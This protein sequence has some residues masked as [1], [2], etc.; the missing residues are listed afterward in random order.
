M[1]EE[2]AVRT[3]MVIFAETNETE[4]YREHAGM[5]KDRDGIVGGFELWGVWRE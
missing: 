3:N 4:A 2:N 5:Y 1:G